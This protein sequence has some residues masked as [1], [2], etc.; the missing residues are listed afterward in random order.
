MRAVIAMIII[1]AAIIAIVIWSGSR[2]DDPNRIPDES[3]VTVVDRS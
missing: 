2:K 3:E 1:G